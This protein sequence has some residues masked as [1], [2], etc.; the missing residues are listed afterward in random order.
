MKDLG[1]YNTYEFKNQLYEDRLTRVNNGGTG[2]SGGNDD[3]DIGGGDNNLPTLPLVNLSLQD[4]FVQ[5]YYMV[6]ENH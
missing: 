3:T 2:D 1:I 4:P 5:K 6:V